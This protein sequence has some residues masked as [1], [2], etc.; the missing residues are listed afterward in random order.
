M[1]KQILSI[2][3]A[4]LVIVFLPQPVFAQEKMAG[5]SAVLENSLPDADQRV[6]KLE[7]FLESYD[8]PLAEY[9]Q[10]FVESADK[11]GLD[12]K[13]VP[14]I[15]GVESTF[16]K[17]IPAGSYNA[18]GWANGAYAFKSWEESIE[19]VSKALKEKYV[20]QGLDTPF[21]I[22]PVYAPPSKTWANK[23]VSFMN[24]LECFDELEC[25]DS[26]D[27]TL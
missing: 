24:K 26:L 2:L 15:T 21:K 25:L 14:A 12:W 23:V 11:Y 19:V 1:K 3:I 4:F 6:S 22:G 13:L 18:Y 7:K 20:D 16:G 8:S 9:A 27:F 5:G 17:Q 10:V